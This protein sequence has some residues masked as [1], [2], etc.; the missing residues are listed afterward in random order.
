MPSIKPSNAP[1]WAKGMGEEEEAMVEEEE[2]VVGEE[3]TL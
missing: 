1:L 3:E 2:A